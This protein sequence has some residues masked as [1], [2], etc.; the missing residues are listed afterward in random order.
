MKKW[1]F[2]MLAL[3]IC[4]LAGAV[5]VGARQVPKIKLAY[6]VLPFNLPSLVEREQSLLLNLG[7]DVS[8]YNFLVG[9]AMT[10][11]MVS[12][13]LDLAPVMGATSTIVSQAGGR[14]LKI[15]GVYSQAPQAF[16]LAVLPQTISLEELK[17]AKI[18]VPL[19]TEA[20]VLLS[21]ILQEQ[22]LSLQDVQLVN[23]LVPDGITALQS[24]QVEAAMVVDPVLSKLEQ[25]GKIEILRDGED[26][27]SGLTLSVVPKSLLDDP[28]V[29]AFQQA[30]RASLNYIQEH[31]EQALDLAI[32]Q[33]DLPRE[34]VTK[35]AAKYNFNPEITDAIKLELESTIDFLFKQQLIRKQ[36]DLEE[37]F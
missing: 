8:Y 12:G 7:Y 28:R 5:T 36:V 21:K 27:I 11:A 19:G 22:G 37:L 6:N 15:I 17:N 34:I 10:E 33:L 24:G 1:Q 2:I 30:H 25:A 26:L 9:H 23:L 31:P 20:H 14:E 32:A 35:I 13:D 4:C 29:V 16:G 3:L 18:A